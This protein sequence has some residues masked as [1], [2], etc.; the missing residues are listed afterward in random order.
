MMSETNKRSQQ[1]IHEKKKKSDSNFLLRSVLSFLYPFF[2][3]LLFTELNKS[4]E[5][6]G[7]EFTDVTVRDRE[8]RTVQ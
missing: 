6:D 4:P 3:F 2:T 1:F 7:S 5:S 8:T